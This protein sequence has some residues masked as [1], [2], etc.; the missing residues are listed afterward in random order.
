MSENLLSCSTTID[1]RLLTIDIV[2][3]KSHIP[4]YEI[5]RNDQ[6]V[7]DVDHWAQSW[8]VPDCSKLGDHIQIA[9]YLPEHTGQNLYLTTE[10]E[11]DVTQYYD[12]GLILNFKEQQIG[13]VVVTRKGETDVI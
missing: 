10:F 2:I 13:R 8:L 1:E 4:D 6:I 9:V 12:K 11:E 7:V 5:R 3:N